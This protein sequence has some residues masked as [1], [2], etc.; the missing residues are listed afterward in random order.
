MK[1]F[2]TKKRLIFTSLILVLGLIFVCNFANAGAL[3]VGIEYGAG[4]GLGTQDIR[5]T[6]ANIIR[7]FL[8]F[9]GI[10]AVALIIYGGYLYMTAAGMPE[11]IDKAKKLL[12][13]AVIGLVIILSAFA[14][15]SFVIS[16]LVSVT[17]PTEPP[18]PPG[19]PSPPPPSPGPTIYCADP[20]PNDSKPWL[21]IDPDSGLRGAGV[22][23]TGGLVGDE[24]GRLFFK[25]KDGNE[26]PAEILK[27]KEDDPDWF[28]P[29]SDS[30]LSRVVVKVPEEITLEGNDYMVVAET[31]D[32]LLS[33]EKDWGISDRLD[34]F[35]LTGEE[36]ST[37]PILICLLDENNNE[38]YSAKTGDFRGLKGERFGVTGT[39]TYNNVIA[40]TSSWSEE[41]IDSTVP[42]TS[43]G[44]VRV[45]VSTQQ[46]NG[47][48]TD[49]ICETDADCLSD[50]CI[51]QICQDAEYC[52]P[53][54]GESCDADTETEACEI[55]DCYPGLVCDSET[56]TCQEKPGPGEECVEVDGALCTDA[57]CQEGLYCDENCICQERGMGFP[58]DEDDD[59]ATG[60]QA[61]D[62][63]CGPEFYC[64]GTEDCTC[65][66]LP[67][68]DDVQPD[69]GA[70]GNFITL[71]GRGFGTSLGRVIFLGD[72]ADLADDVNAVLPLGCGAE[73][74]WQDDQLIIEIPEEAVT[75]PL[76]LINADGLEETTS[77]EDGW[78]GD[79]K[80]NNI[81]RPALC[82]L[83]PSQG[84]F[85][86]S[87]A[88]GGKNFGETK[89]RALIGG[90][91]FDN[92]ANWSWSDIEIS[93][94]L[95]PNIEPEILSVQVQ[96]S[97]LFSN[98]FNFTVLPSAIAPRID[99]ISPNFGPV[100]Q[101][102]TI[103]GSNF[104][105]QE[106]SVRFDNN[107][108]DQEDWQR[109]DTDFPEA[110]QAKFWSNTSVVVKVPDV[111]DGTSSPDSQIVLETAEGLFT[112]TV[113]FRVCQQDPETC[114]LRPGICLLEPDQGPI[115]T[116]DITLYGENFDSYD[117]DSE[118]SKVFFWDD[119][120]VADDLSNYWTENQVGSGQVRSG[121]PMT[122]PEGAVT[123]PVELIDQNGLVSN[124]MQFEVIDCRDDPSICDTE[125]TGLICCELDGVCRL[126]EDC[127][128][129]VAPMCT[130]KWSFTTGLDIDVEPPQVIE[131]LPCEENTQSPTPWKNS[132]DNC[133][134]IWISA[135]FTQKM[136]VASL[137][138]NT[139]IVQKCNDDGAFEENLC[140]PR[141]LEPLAI[142][143]INED[144]GFVFEPRTEHPDNYL[145]PNTW[146]KVTLKSGRDG[147]KSA[148]ELGNYWLDGDFDGIEGGDYSWHF[149][150]RNSAEACEID[151]VVVNPQE[152]LIELI[153]EDQE[154]NAFALAENCNILN[155]NAYD[156]TWYKVYSDG[157]REEA[158][159]TLEDYGI[160]TISEQDI[161]PR[162]RDE[163]GNIISEGNNKIDYKQIAT[164]IDQGLTYI[165]AEVFPDSPDNE[166]DEDNELVIDLNLPEIDR[167]YPNNGLIHP[168]INAYVTIYG[169]N[170]GDEPLAGGVTFEE[171]PAELVDCGDPWTDEIIQVL[172]PKAKPVEAEQ[173]ATYNLPELVDRNGMILFYSFEDTG[174]VIL[175][176]QLGNYEGEIMGSPQRVSDQFGQAMLFNGVSDYVKLPN[177]LDL[178]TGS[179][180]L[181][182]KPEQAGQQTL[183]SASDG[184][185]DLFSLDLESG[186][187]N[188]TDLNLVINGQFNKTIGAPVKW[189]NWNHLVYTFDG[190]K[191]NIYINGVK[192]Q[193]LASE[194]NLANNNLSQ[195]GFLADVINK[196]DVLI[197]A[198][199]SQG[200]KDY[201]KG[202]M[203]GF[204]IYDRV[205]GAGEVRNNYGLQSGQT[206]LLN[207]EGTGEQIIDSS[208]N[209]F[210]GVSIADPSKSFRIDEGRYGKAISFNN[211]NHI[212]IADNPALRFYKGITIEGWFKVSDTQDNVIFE[213]GDNLSVRIV[214]DSLLFSVFVADEGEKTGSSVYAETSNGINIDQW[215]YFAGVYD[216]EKVKIY[217]NGQQAEYDEPGR[218]YK[219]DIYGDSCLGGCDNEFTGAL[220]EIVVYNRALSEG[221]IQSRLGAKDGS[222]VY[223]QTL[224][225][226]AKSDRTFIY[227]ENV[228]PFLCDLQPDFGLEGTEVALDGDNF[229]DS[230]KTTY[231]GKEYG[232]G[233][234]TIFDADFL[235]DEN[236]RG[237]TNKLVEAI[238]PFSD[239]GYP[240]IDVSISIDPY[241]E[242][243]N[244]LTGDG[245]FTPCAEGQ[246]EGCD[247]YADINSN[248]EY[249]SGT[250]SVENFETGNTEQNTEQVDSLES[251]TLPFYLPPVIEK[252]S[253]DNGPIG[254]WVT[255][256]GY[257][258]GEYV[259]G[260][261]KVF[262]YNDKEALF[263]PPPCDNYWTNTQIIVEVPEGAEPGDL[264]LITGTGLESNR[265]NYEV[266]DDPLGAGICQITPTFGEPDEVVVVQGDR[267]EVEKGNS[268]LIFTDRAIATT[269]YWDN[270]TITG[271]V[272]AGAET[273]EV[274]VT[275]RIET[276]R[277]CAGFSIGTWCPSGQYDIVYEDVP[278][279]P[280]N[281][282][283]FGGCEVTG[284]GKIGRKE[285]VLSGFPIRPHDQAGKIASYVNTYNST[286][287][288][289]YLYAR[290]DTTWWNWR[291]SYD[292][293]ISGVNPRNIIYKIGTGYNG[294]ELGR[295]Y[296][297]YVW[298]DR[299]QPDSS[300]QVI[301][302]PSI[303][304]HSDG[305]FY[306]G[307]TYAEGGNWW[308]PEIIFDDETNEFYLQQ[309]A[310]L[311]SPFLNFV[312]GIINAARNISNGS[313]INGGL[314][315]SN[316]QYVF[317]VAQI[318]FWWGKTYK[319]KIYDPKNNWRL[320]KSFTVDDLPNGVAGPLGIAVDENIIYISNYYNNSSIGVVALNWHS[321][322]YV[323]SWS[324]N[325]LSP[326]EENEAIGGYDWEN[327]VFWTGE[328]S[329]VR[330]AE[331]NRI[332]K[333][334]ACPL[335]GAADQCKTDLDCNACGEGTSSCING[336]CT[337]YIMEFTPNSGAVG[338]W[339]ALNGCYFGCD[340]G[341]V[342]FWGK[343]AE[344]MEDL[345]SLQDYKAYYS[346]D[347]DT[348]NDAS[349]NEYHGE[350]KGD[351][352]ID[353]G[354]LNLNGTG[355]YVALPISYGQSE[356]PETTVCARVKSS[357]QQAQIIA[358]F[359]RSEVW[360]LAL[361]DTVPTGA[362]NV[363]WDT[364]DSLDQTRDLS[365]ESD[366]ADG[367]WHYICGW[368]NTNASPNKRIYV[369]GEQVAA[370]TT[371]GDKSLGAGQ[372]RSQSFGFIGVGSEARKPDGV[373][374]PESWFYGQIDEL[375]IYDRALTDV[376]IQVLAGKQA[377]G[378]I[379]EALNVGE[380]NPDCGETWRC[381]PDD[382]D[383][384]IVEVPNQD[385]E[386]NMDCPEGD[387]PPEGYDLNDAIDGPIKLITAFGAPYEDTT[388]HLDPANYDVDDVSVPNLCRLTPD[389]GNQGITVRAI[390]ENFADLQAN[391]YIKFG[392]NSELSELREPWYDYG[393]DGLPS[394]QEDGYD[395]EINPDPASDDF[396]SSSNPDGTE[397]NNQYDYDE[398]EGIGELFIDVNEN[399]LYDTDLSAD[400]YSFKITD[401]INEQ[402]FN[403][404]PADDG[405]AN[406]NICFKVPEDAAG[407]GTTFGTG[408]NQVQVSKDIN[409]QDILS[410]A[411]RFDVS[412]GACGDKIIDRGLGEMCDDGT[413]PEI[414]DSELEE[415]C[416]KLFSERPDE[417]IDQCYADCADDCNLMFCIGNDCRSI[418]DLCGNNIIS[419]YPE[420]NYMEDC[421]CGEEWQC[422][423]V[424]LNNQTCETLELEPGELS[425]YPP[426][427]N[428]QCEFD[429]S[430]CSLLEL[431]QFKVQATM[432]N[433]GEEEF[434]T[435]GIVDIYFD[436]LIDESTLENHIRIASCSDSTFARQQ[437]KGL[438]Y[439]TVQ[440]FKNIFKRLVGYDRQALAQECTEFSSEE[441]ELETLNAYDKTIV[442]LFT[443]NFLDSEQ[444]YQVT[445]IGG[446]IGIKS[447]AGGQLDNSNSPWPDPLADSEDY[448]FGFK[449]LGE[450]D[451][452]QSG[453]CNVEWIDVSVYSKPFTIWDNRN[454][455]FRDD[456]LFMCAGRDDCALD[457]DFDQD[458]ATEGNQH[459]YDAI[460]KS[461]KGFSLKANYQWSKTDDTDPQRAIEIYND[462][463]ELTGGDSSEDDYKVQNDTG[464][465][466]VTAK[467]IEE[468]FAQLAIE[469]QAKGSFEPPAQENFDVYI[470]LCE[471]PWPSIQEKFPISSLINAY[472]F[473]TY[474][475][476][477][478]G[479]P[480]PAGDLPAA[481]W[482]FPDVAN[483]SNLT[484][485]DFEYGNLLNWVEATGTAF[486][487]QPV[488]TDITS[489]RDGI[490]S[491]IQGNWWIGTYER[492]RGNYWEETT[493]IQDTKPTGV[494]HSQA[495]LIE[496]NE[497]RFKIGGS[498][499]PWPEASYSYS[500]DD[501]NN[502]NAVVWAI[503]D[504]PEK[505]WQIVDSATGE[506][507]TT[508]REE[509][510]DTAK[511]MTGRQCSDD[512]DCNGYGTC[513]DL[514]GSICG[515][516]PGEECQC[517]PVAGIIY[518]Y[519]NNFGG[520]T[521]FDDLRQYKNGIEIPIRF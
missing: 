223:V 180:E 311:P 47:L 4:T 216:G 45:T 475:C 478:A 262:F 151:N 481:R 499:N 508:M 308:V 208:V 251:N 26:F 293:N 337:P 95:I 75:G 321:E 241:S 160:A 319:V 101:Y 476:R 213:Q 417:E 257:N 412:F 324:K 222:Y 340:P 309:S 317:N 243:Y 145:K 277:A 385:I 233:S 253:P 155:G 172:A 473:Q 381:N 394:E 284:S 310:S 140:S 368:F 408:R 400:D 43:S 225:G 432:P 136:D 461:K 127:E 88:L 111:P 124:Q 30:E 196:T 69:N 3:D 78:V 350:L 338:T 246:T 411:L 173:Q 424:G 235:G 289:T 120:E 128:M 486:D 401:Y 193:Y 469:A 449:T 509:I 9:L 463:P 325:N 182:F 84:E 32:E 292:S 174:G 66:Y 138:K 426:G 12:T 123:G 171:V 367:N 100:G 299:I 244:D 516:L 456:D 133:A 281:F 291:L 72:E 263:P 38:V 150:I 115:G 159:E 94:A 378:Y 42:G 264:Y 44:K 374:S 371:P 119:K 306:P 440:Y 211:D 303:T 11:K 19:P 369:D 398:K 339:V 490:S 479:P 491:Q 487:S 80:I 506:D 352:S 283:V 488:Y 201:F 484:N 329:L 1:N 74:I 331:K 288:G 149:R 387:C 358:S 353:Q 59:P 501:S 464:I 258:F 335:T 161:R 112:N 23:V 229:G 269:S 105:N 295:I 110:C 515:D 252:I 441:Y 41:F 349:A 413:M 254:T 379:K 444:Y 8:G 117:Y 348:A 300:E 465:T 519:D 39:V 294:T 260:E 158:S 90:M 383:E 267:F 419:N 489:Q 345:T 333:Y 55:S 437:N 226:K 63:K 313:L 131:E 203:D 179:L 61:D 397:G 415:I 404:C 384:V 227:S 183:F 512:N 513:K 342:Y 434:C 188:G 271:N 217:L 230:N 341:Q 320:V 107:E 121:L 302:L 92:K 28:K 395:P 70:P 139:I 164:P 197:G 365:T 18:G 37:A 189:N 507:R 221:E 49:I 29:I 168:D 496:G 46:S 393:L 330:D 327:R 91:E 296:N 103:F 50:C 157:T 116:T 455:E 301:Y 272:P 466:F 206:L 54:I 286:S 266:N 106:G 521:N 275:K 356:L 220:D 89:E 364:T 446:E 492:Y 332:S 35:R 207:F 109:A 483:L 194:G 503:R 187:E 130:Y 382:Y 27:C 24:P 265:V 347:D 250:Y 314:I 98:P 170:F 438:V 77:D 236:I 167:I 312:G 52:L 421:D 366:Y 76:K 322:E 17:A 450:A 212:N 135:R 502:A 162:I 192:L 185:D 238:N 261:S 15:A 214:D 406:E 495:F 359:D 147:I 186:T 228:Y 454:A 176:D 36:L 389:L 458:P 279:N 318:K 420:L 305:K 129:E 405:W 471:N 97:E 256:S 169:K 435:N 64:S 71:W 237:W 445:I 346:F 391:D 219:Q 282:T 276:G 430:A 104:G 470:L 205:L 363:G 517:T 396:D 468:A 65:Q 247:E 399:G 287:D 175:E 410:S 477:D 34:V 191:Y 25:D 224:F 202:T 33:S 433:H 215:N 154:Y 270:K 125:N 122:V 505:E 93:N 442:S 67:R 447:L 316:G 259:K 153:T 177:T 86:E 497:I 414:E 453:I 482:L 209:N 418:L 520:Y 132:V 20:N 53:Y 57:G 184:S 73:N 102:V 390:G 83:T 514:E 16:R 51:S 248:F 85:G 142:D 240:E 343:T 459:E 436:D 355:D 5:I 190:E 144:T 204:A 372:E 126:P 239:I 362:A 178:E 156:W 351:A 40:E 448:I 377:T 87:V 326:N 31:A 360:R 315:D 13:G 297:E 60:C 409:G 2:L 268:N 198:K 48:W 443:D 392:P 354:I 467:P 485:T 148:L 290:T 232:V 457:L 304:Y 429:T 376:E 231:E 58:C 386:P 510:F 242:P 498:N 451:D 14:I 427:H 361:K 255:I 402:E 195:Q 273:G 146:Y 79:F 474:Y 285:A 370:V 460:G 56:C 407:Y 452:P 439:K 137:N 99:Y 166:K 518:I 245:F 403:A 143:T 334:V 165:G 22:T 298:R 344:Q 511:F 249:D 218:Y 380:K 234:Y 21:C 6:I 114:P 425:C 375:R 199:N 323:T 152:A 462:K 373:K 10:L 118:Q 422:T 163:S 504:D 388:E 500:V 428:E 141:P 328:L 113:D 307:L 108:P 274:V 200:I 278:S 480:G 493:D 81:V 472:N 494:L 210:Q 82:S 336:R 280:V 423:V 181:W 416:Q 431:P 134:N 62:T 96:V 7:G 68:I 357:S